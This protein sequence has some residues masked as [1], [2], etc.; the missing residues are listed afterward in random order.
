[1]LRN[2]VQIIIQISY[3][4]DKKLCQTVH[5]ALLCV[6]HILP[7]MQP[8][9]NITPNVRSHHCERRCTYTQQLLPSNTVR[10][11]YPSPVLAGLFRVR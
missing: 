3:C 8:I 4:S 1:M 9:L 7:A 10:F 6:V 11:V 2:C 5:H